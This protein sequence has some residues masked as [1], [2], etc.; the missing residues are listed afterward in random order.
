MRQLKFL[1]LTDHRGHSE[2]NS[3]YALA[4]TLAAD[5]RTASV[6][7]ASRGDGRNDAFFAGDLAAAAYGPVVGDRFAFD[8]TGAQFAGA[9]ECQRYGE[10]DAVWLRLPPPAD[11]SFFARLTTPAPA[12]APENA[13]L[14]FNDPAGIL[15][16]GSKAFLRHFPELTAPTRWVRSA[17]DI[18]DFAA[19][20]PIVLKPLQ[21]YGG[22]GLV[23]VA[24][25]TAEADGQTYALADWLA[26]SAPD[27]AA[28]HYLAMKFLK[29]VTAGDKRIL[30][31]NGK[32]L[33][34]SLRLPAPG[35]WLCNVAQGGRSLPSQ[36]TPAEEA[37]VATVAPAL[38]ERGVVMFGVDTLAD[39]DGRRV[40]SELNTNSVGGFPQAEAQSG[41]PVLQQ[42]IDGIYDYLYARL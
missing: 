36:P 40:L 42:T 2:Q 18:R 31:V 27:V 24:G 28:G 37:I 19:R 8:P 23:R 16:T 30:V 26:A 4:R 34:A 12:S 25:D 3:L 29:N 39:D 41:R 6:R 20:H 33:G 14:V 13:P 10:A 1:V 38:L 15:A 9:T 22:R 21:E 7:V 5:A 32:I 35:G 17:T 11:R